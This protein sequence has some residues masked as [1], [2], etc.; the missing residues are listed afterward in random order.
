[1][2][3][4]LLATITYFSEDPFNCIESNHEH[5]VRN[6]I[7]REDAQSQLTNI[8]MHSIG[9]PD[10]MLLFIIMHLASALVH[11][12]NAIFTMHPAFPCIF[13]IQ[14]PTFSTVPDT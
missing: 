8:L 14:S 12:L 10:T 5:F 3:E 11:I 6:N 9:I 13:I 2:Q 7:L 1:M 4:D